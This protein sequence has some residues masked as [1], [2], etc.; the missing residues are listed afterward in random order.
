M[1]KN[2]KV[3]SLGELAEIIATLRSGDTSPKVVHC[4]GVFDLL[5]IGHIR[6]LEQARTLGDVLV[7]TLTEDRYVNKGPHRPAFT[8]SLRAEAL[9]ALGCVDY[10]AVNQ[11]PTAVNTIELLKPDIYAKGA[12]FK[13]N[14]TEEILREQTAIQ[15]SGGELQYIEDLTSS[16]SSLINRHLSV[17]PEEVQQYLEGFGKRYTADAVLRY[18][19]QMRP[20]KTLVVGEAIID[21]YHYC[22]AIGKSSKEP[23][24]AAKY[25]SEER[26]AGG[27]LAVGNHVANFCDQVGLVTFLGTENSHRDFVEQHLSPNIERMFLQKEQTPTIVKRRFVESYFLSKFF[28]IYVIDD[29][30]LDT[31]EN[32]HLCAKLDAHLPEFDV[33][34]VTDFGHGMLT[35][36]AIALLGSKAKFL[37][38]NTQVNAGNRGFNTISKYPRADYICLNE[39]EIRLELRDLH[40]DIRELAQGVSQQ[41]NCE[42]ILITRGKNGILCYS[43]AEG[44]FEVPA[45]ANRVVD[46]VGAGDA[47]LSLTSLCVAQGVPIEIVGFIGNV[48]GTQAVGTVGNRTAI[49]RTPLVRH[50]ISLLK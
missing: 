50:I 23:A 27:I 38:V 30:I 29:R 37:A 22:E 25:L 24:L 12:E 39:T 7:V 1:K 32:Q 9:A 31:S 3:K 36:E 43:A 28:E 19:E 40:T 41:L 2:G 26:F 21:E 44:F 6:Y 13:E 48:A 15:K 35:K 5:H 10:V 8:E 16:S 11:W 34:I 4:H 42:H 33:V 18:I 17:F 47:V 45:F 20:L 14:P 46:R 49:E